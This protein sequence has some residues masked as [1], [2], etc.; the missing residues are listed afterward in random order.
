MADYYTQGS[1]A[2][3]CSHA[4]MAL[5]E[6][7]FQASHDLENGDTPSQPTPEFLA[8]FPPTSPDD[9]WS[10][11]VTLFDD[12][13]FPSFGVEFEGGNTLDQPGVSTVS[14]WSMIDFQ[15]AALAALIHRCC[16]ETVRQAPI[17]FE[18]GFSCSRAR[19]DGFGGGWCAVF[20]DRIEI[21]TTRQAL[22]LALEGGI[23]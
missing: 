3:T 13:E 6:E 20:A 10:G 5:I 2:F 22:S 1:F 21:E 7:A 17:G 9:T 23:L 14:M 4:E 15:P 19:R 18:F 11:F 8:A 16:Q 12:P